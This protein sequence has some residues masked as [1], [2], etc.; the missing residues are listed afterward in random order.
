MTMN[1]GDTGNEVKW[2][3][4]F[5]TQKAKPISASI[6]PQGKQYLETN[7]GM[8]KPYQIL[9]EL[10]G[11]GGSMGLQDIANEIRMPYQQVKNILMNMQS[12]GYVALRSQ[13]E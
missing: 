10:N 7:V 1:Y 13:S 12:H 5:T 8:G 9:S 2:R 4:P 6:T 11:R 3:I